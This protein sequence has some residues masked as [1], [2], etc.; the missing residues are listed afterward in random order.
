[1]LK[2]CFNRFVYE[3]GCDEA[4]R[5]SLAGPVYAAA[6]ILPDDYLNPLLNDSKRLSEKTRYQLRLEIERDAVAWAVASVDNG[7]IDRLNILVT[8]FMAMH[9]ALDNLT[10]KPGHIIVD[11]NSFLRYRS[12]PHTCIVKGDQQF[13]SIAAA[14]ILA[15]TYRD[16]C[17]NDLHQAFP[18]Y[19]WNKNKGYATPFHRRA[20]KACGISSF[21]RKSFSL[22]NEQLDLDF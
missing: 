6:V 14:S 18:Q 15:K 2:S 3:A 20:I 13:A 22:L 5:G 10:I 7:T 19:G 1:M 16:D 11:G 4:G 17:M 21:H 8:S 9:R 12:V